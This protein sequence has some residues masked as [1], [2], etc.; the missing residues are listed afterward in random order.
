[1]HMR[2]EPVL[3]MVFLTA[4][5][6]AAVSCQGPAASPPRLQAPVPGSPSVAASVTVPLAVPAGE[7]GGA[8]AV[9]RKLKLPRGWTARVWARGP[10]ARMEAWTPQG[11]L[12]VSEPDNGEVVEL[13]PDSRGTAHVRTLLKNLTE[14]QGLAFARVSGRWVLY[15]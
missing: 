8:F 6:L 7:G 11:K 2:A 13:T 12:L 10:D 4:G 1:M 3:R 15:V 14:P 5:L 9:L